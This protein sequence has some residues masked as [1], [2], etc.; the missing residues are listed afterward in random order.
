MPLVS[1]PARN[2]ARSHPRLP[3]GLHVAHHKPHLRWAAEYPE[4]LLPGMTQ[5]ARQYAATFARA[6]HDCR[7][8]P[9]APEWTPEFRRERTAQQTRQYRDAMAPIRVMFGPD[10]THAPVNGRSYAKA[11]GE[12]FEVPLRKFHSQV[13]DA[14]RSAE[15]ALDPFARLCGGE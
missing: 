2:Q 4:E 11:E 15:T 1:K 14:D 8:P 9:G 12:W 13:H 6:Y 5:E 10:E 7:F 3:L